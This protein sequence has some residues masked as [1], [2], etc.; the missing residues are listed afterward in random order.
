MNTISLPSAVTIEPGKNN[1]ARITIEPCSPGYGT[2]IGNALRRVLLSSIPGAAVT[3]IRINGASHEFTG[4]PHVKE[5]M[6]EFILRVKQLRVRLHGSDKA[7]IK[8]KVTGKKAVTAGD[9]SASS[10]VEIGNPEL[11][12]LTL[13]DDKAA[14]DIDFTVE[15]GLGY[16]PVEAREKQATEDVNA[17]KVDAV[18]TPL[19]TVNFTVEHVRVGQ[20][21]NFDKLMLDI[22]TDGTITPAAAF[23]QSVQ[24]LVEH[25]NFLQ[26]QAA[27]FPADAPEKK[28][29]SKKK[30]KE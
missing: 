26:A 1:S 25:F 29:T 4:L 14:I 22:T 23:T 11:H 12:L 28:A 18:F 19:R 21:T 6:V 15:P 7:V 27:T 2:T 3:D 17:I 10:D 24:L 30:K 5:D 9:I 8:L 13:T 16:L 20:M